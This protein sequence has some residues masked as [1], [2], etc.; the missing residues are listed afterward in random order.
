MGR[1]IASCPWQGVRLLCSTCPPLGGGGV[2]KR[3]SRFCSHSANISGQHF[4]E[5]IFIFF[6][7]HRIAN[8]NTFSTAIFL[9]L[10]T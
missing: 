3:W 7:T 1:E 9:H 6:C 5:N 8:P 2:K 4:S 10:L